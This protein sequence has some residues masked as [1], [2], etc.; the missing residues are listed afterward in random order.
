[1]LIKLY[2][3]DYDFIQANEVVL[4]D[5]YDI[6]ANIDNKLVR[7]GEGVRVN[8]ISDIA[9]MIINK[10]FQ[11]G[12][13]MQRMKLSPSDMILRV[14]SRNGRFMVG[15]REKKLPE[16]GAWMRRMLNISQAPQY[17]P[18]LPYLILEKKDV[19]SD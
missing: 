9:Y 5:R 18:Y 1:M 6:M 15:K 10:T 3:H 19:V 11:L 4:D 8:N 7:V 12:Y 14:E 17:E 13:W 2:H 16:G